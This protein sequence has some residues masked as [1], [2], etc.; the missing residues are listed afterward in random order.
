MS[1]KKVIVLAETNPTSKLIAERAKELYNAKIILDENPKD[2]T[3]DKL[4]KILSK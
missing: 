4:I 1:I 3:D 2:I